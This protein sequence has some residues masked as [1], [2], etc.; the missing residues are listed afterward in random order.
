MP[1]LVHH[2]D[3]DA[4]TVSD[5]HRFPMRKYSLVASA[6]RA[7]GA[8]FHEPV[9]APVQWLQLAHDAAYVDAVL[10][11]TLDRAASRKIGFEI[12]PAIA[13]RS[14]ASC[15]GTALAAR[16]AIEYGAAANLAGG[17]HHAF[18]ESGAGF[19]VFNDVAVAA[20]LLLSEGL[21]RRIAVIDCDVHHGDGTA[22]IF[23]DDPRVFTA[24]L[25]CEDNWPRTKPPS[26]LDIGLPKGAGDAD[27]SA[28]LDALLEQVFTAGP[29]DLVFFNAGVDPHTEDRLGL[30][31]LSDHGL[32][33]RDLRVAEACAARGTPICGVLG[34]GYGKDPAQVAARHLYMVSALGAVMSR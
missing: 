8:T 14:R 12:T 10:T 3:Y 18:R 28:A 2:P 16:L 24:S 33:T 34:G 9:H 29:F 20:T 4:A 5:D 21:V 15:A 11:S 7:R 1:P 30:L 6:L 32:E 26:D 17:S 22:S 25:H 23:A 19:C 27:Y 31:E 13:R